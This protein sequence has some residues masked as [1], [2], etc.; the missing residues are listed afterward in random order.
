MHSSI[1]ISTTFF[2]VEFMAAN[3]Q[4]NG[5]S[6]LWDAFDFSPETGLDSFLRTAAIRTH[7]FPVIGSFQVRWFVR[8]YFF[9]FSYI[10]SST[11]NL[12]TS[13]KSYISKFDT[14]VVKRLVVNY[15]LRSKRVF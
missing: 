6:Q 5:I 2:A 8:E 10:F 4:R 1:K 13:Q 15:N 3:M 12:L 7:S 14:S 9:D 11:K